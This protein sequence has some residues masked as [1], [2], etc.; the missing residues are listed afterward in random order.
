MCLSSYPQ[1]A[2]FMVCTAFLDVSALHLIGYHGEKYAPIKLRE[3]CT[4]WVSSTYK[5]PCI[6]STFVCFGYTETVCKTTH[7][8][9][10]TAVKKFGYP[11]CQPDEQQEISL[12]ID[13]K[14]R[15]V[16]QTLNCRCA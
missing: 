12:T 15:R 5:N 6:D 14:K 3:L 16:V 1:V 11:K 9:C 2:I 7:A 13:G 8:S 4:G 10:G